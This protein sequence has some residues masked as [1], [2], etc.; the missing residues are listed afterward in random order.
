MSSH[1]PKGIDIKPIEG[2]SLFSV[3]K[4]DNV[5][6]K[7]NYELLSGEYIRL[8]SLG[9]EA[10]TT[11][12]INLKLSVV[13]QTKLDTTLRLKNDESAFDC[14]SLYLHSDMSKEWRK[15]RV[16]ESKIKTGFEEKQNSVI[17]L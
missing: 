5:T 16:A 12:Q 17:G 6:Q 14:Y 10:R 4:R 9:K 7:L 1:L 15:C 13:T 2:S 8:Q 3:L 11:G